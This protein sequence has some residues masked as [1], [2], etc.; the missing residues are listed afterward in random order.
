MPNSTAFRVN[1]TKNE[2]R[3]IKRSDVLRTQYMNEMETS[4]TR[5]FLL[6]KVDV[7]D[8]IQYA[9]MGMVERDHSRWEA[10]FS[11]RCNNYKR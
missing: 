4:S 10:S 2:K 7:S 3:A 11:N 6:M 5:Y 9:N 8:V 1:E